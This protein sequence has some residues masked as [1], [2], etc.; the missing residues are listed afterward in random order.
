MDQLPAQPVE[1][2]T[3]RDDVSVDMTVEV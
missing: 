3:V 2:V 1:Q